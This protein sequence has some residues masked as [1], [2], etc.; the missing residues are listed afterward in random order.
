MTTGPAAR[1]PGTARAPIG[2]PVDRAQVQRRV[3]RVL[4]CTQV[5]GGIGVSIGLAVSTL[6]AAQMSGS[7][8]IGGTAL[9]CAVVG[10]A[11]AA[12]VLAR[13]AARSGRRWSLTTGYLVGA[14]GA[15]VAMLAGQLG[16][17][18]LL[19]AGLVLLGGATAAG[20]AARFAATDLAAPHRRARALA[21]VVWATTVG[22]VAGPNLG[23]PAQR[24]GT[25]LGLE[26]AAGP[27]L[28]CLLVFAL[29]ATLTG[30]GLR[31]D[32]LVLA[33]AP[34]TGPDSG[35][36]RPTVSGRAALRAAPAARLG[37]A[38]IVL[39]HLIMVG[40]MSMTPVHMGHGGATLQLVGLVISL[41]VAGMYAL[42]P[43]FGWL[44]DRAGSRPVL[45]MAA[46]L[47]VAA[48]GVGS[49]ASG[50]QT[51]LLSVGLVLLGLGWSA[52]L[53]AGS[54]LLTVAVPVPERTAVQGLADVSMNVA[55]A[56]GGI[57]AGLTVSGASF[58]VLGVG[59]ALLALPY[60]VA[61]LLARPRT[62]PAE[63]G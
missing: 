31:P 50:Q 42:S 27:F 32:P 38:G 41:H 62:L 60:L 34:A 40:L 29:A 53:V 56:V 57:V 3:L 20:L 51:A 5:L 48:G 44:V 59:C 23:A 54:A 30:T 10:A 12:V 7:D 49:I 19:L 21:T 14:V 11:A 2:P 1:E 8:A 4:V 28:C 47:L 39:C 6:I 33:R 58:G 43:V 63:A 52:G 37:V 25:L 13:I 36:G 46:V 18:P 45:G 55:G 24:L 35:A 26:P 15:A 16:R 9:T 61:V 17:W 22:A